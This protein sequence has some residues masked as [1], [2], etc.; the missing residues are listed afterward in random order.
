M[1]L[2]AGKDLAAIYFAG[3]GSIR[4]GGGTAGCVCTR[5]VVI[6]ES[7]QSAPVPWVQVWR[8]GKPF[9]QFNAAMLE[10]VEYEQEPVPAP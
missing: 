3:G 10:G 7:G 2:T 9:Q 4:L 1:E 5:L 8:E 6:E